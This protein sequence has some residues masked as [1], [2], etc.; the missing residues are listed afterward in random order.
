MTTKSSRKSGFTLIELLVVIT[1][2]G[3]LAGLAVPAIS[4]AL[5]KA[6]QTADVA[7][8]RQ[9]GIIFFGVANDEGG[10]YP[11]GVYN[12]AATR[13]DVGNTV[14]LFEGM[15]VDGD[16]TDPKIVSTNG[17]VPYKG[18]LTTPNMTANNVGWE[19]LEGL[20]TTSNASIPLFVTK[21]A[22]TTA[23]AL[24]GAAGATIALPDTHVWGDK[25]MAVYYVGNSAEWLK[26]RGGNV[27][28]PIQDSGVI[29]TG[30]TLMQAE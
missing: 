17:T 25:G 26:A 19:Y 1:I 27:A 16:L 23:G 2:I 9:L 12:G 20:T 24:E 11:V 4:G 30:V 15:L 21:G 22:V 8:A 5:D 18:S 7:N 14:D 28:T 13:T 29:P 3:L 6:K 10:V